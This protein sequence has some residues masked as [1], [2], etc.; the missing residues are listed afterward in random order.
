MLSGRIFYVCLHHKC[1]WSDCLIGQTPSVIRFSIGPP[2][3]RYR[4]AAAHAAVGRI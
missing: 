4:P 1:S 3:Q 2:F